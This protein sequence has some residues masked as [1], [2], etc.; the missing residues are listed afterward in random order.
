MSRYDGKPF[1]KLLDCYVLSSIGH[2]AEDQEQALN[3]MAPKLAE[4]FGV[5]GSWFDIVATQ[6]NLPHDFPQNIKRI[7]LQGKAKA[8]EQGFSVDPEEFAHHFV[9]TNLSPS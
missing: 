2:L 4:T 6:M 5:R 3:A 1:L 7:W 8:E 9:D